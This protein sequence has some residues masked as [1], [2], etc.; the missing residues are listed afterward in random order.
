MEYLFIP[1]VFAAAA[2]ALAKGK[3]RNIFLWAALGL[4]IGPI[5]ALIV[6]MMKSAPGPEQDYK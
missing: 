1:I 2:G 4:I 3:N 6:A 5:A